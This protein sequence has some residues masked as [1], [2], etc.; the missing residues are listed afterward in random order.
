[1][2]AAGIQPQYS[3]WVIKGDQMEWSEWS[4]KL[5]LSFLSY[6]KT[7]CREG[8]ESNVSLNTNNLVLANTFKE[9]LAEK[10]IYK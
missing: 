5:F 4:V 1:M 7:R 8:V 9:I 2:K 10:Y 6:K 3:L